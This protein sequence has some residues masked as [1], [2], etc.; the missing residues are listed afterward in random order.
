MTVL[1]RQLVRVDRAEVDGTNAWVV[2]DQDECVVLDAP[3]GGASA[4]AAVAAVVAGRRVQAIL[5]TH[6]HRRHIASALTLSDVTGA[7]VHLHPDDYGL[8][9]EVFPTRW[10]ERV[11]LDGLTVDVARTQLVG[12]H[13]PGHTDGGM[14]WY[15]PELG[16]LFT[17]DS[18]SADGVGPASTGS[19]RARLLSAVR[20]R[21]FTLP[22]ATTLHPGHGPDVRL[23]TVRGDR[24]FWA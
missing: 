11:L 16:A 7:D 22:M 9:H 5:C 4:V 10:P 6:G 18:L 23:G 12:L 24:S 21:L 1:P 2:G 3:A 8:W 17:G 14:C 15:A 20:A 19:D 13:V